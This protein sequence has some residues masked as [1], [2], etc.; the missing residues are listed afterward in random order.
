M[1]SPASLIT[2]APPTR[3]RLRD[4]SGKHAWELPLGVVATA[5]RCH[6]SPM[7]LL[8]AA[9]AATAH[10][11]QPLLALTP[12][13]CAKEYVKPPAGAA[14]AQ[15]YLSDD[16]L[17]RARVGGGCVVCPAGL[18]TLERAGIARSPQKGCQRELASVDTKMAHLECACCTSCSTQRVEQL[19]QH[20][21]SRSTC[22]T[23]APVV[24]MAPPRVLAA[25]LAALACCR[26]GTAVRVF[27]F[28]RFLES[29]LFSCGKS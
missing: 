3:A 8:T 25:R 22:A 13:A 20:T 5:H 4:A 19:V 6:C 28:F 24:N 1:C 9:T 12:W 29:Y 26:G 18:R 16:R 27:H 10:R 21:H 15:A 2:Q 14:V 17:R 23:F 7:P 11:S